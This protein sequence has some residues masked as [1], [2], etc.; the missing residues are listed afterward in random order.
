MR[1]NVLLE[2][3][4]GSTSLVQHQIDGFNRFV[5]NDLQKIIDQQSTIQ[6]SVEGFALKLGKVRLDKPS[7]IEADSSRRSILPN[8]AR[9]RNLTYASPMFLEFVPS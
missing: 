7:I 6:P 4:L 5:E 1:D 9:L 2:S 8:E 3:Y